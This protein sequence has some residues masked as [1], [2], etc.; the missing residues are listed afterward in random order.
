M[1]V[2]IIIEFL[3][4]AEICNAFQVAVMRSFLIHRDNPFFQPN[5]KNNYLKSY[6]ALTFFYG[7]LSL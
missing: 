4:V 2:E 1:K 7:D 6:L 3:L 5:A